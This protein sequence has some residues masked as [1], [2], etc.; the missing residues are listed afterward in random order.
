M[1][2]ERTEEMLMKEVNEY[3]FGVE[4]YY[5]EIEIEEIAND[6]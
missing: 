4:K 5:E 3:A 2:T 1:L 6:N